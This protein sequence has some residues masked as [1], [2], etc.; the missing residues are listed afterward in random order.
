MTVVVLLV[1]AAWLLL[2]FR[3]FRAEWADVAPRSLTIAAAGTTGIDGLVDVA[4]ERTGGGLLRAWSRPSSNGVSVVLAHGSGGDRTQMLEA[5]RILAGE[6]FGVLLYDAP[7]CG[8]SEGTK[9]LGEDQ[10]EAA[11]S[12]IRWV[13]GEP[14]V[15]LVGGLGFSLGAQSL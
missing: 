15:R 8:A 1:V 7:G 14:G 5:A 13:S 10:V 6:G 4:I 9:T 3:S 11:R 12:V 2:N